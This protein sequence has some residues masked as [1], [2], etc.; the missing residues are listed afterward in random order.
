M[1]VKS[2]AFEKEI[3]ENDKEMQQVNFGENEL[4]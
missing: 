1:Y 3:I 2:Y 4:I